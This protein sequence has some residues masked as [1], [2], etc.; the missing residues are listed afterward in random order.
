L[1]ASE[2]RQRS[3]LATIQPEPPPPCSRVACPAVPAELPLT[4]MAFA[5]RVAPGVIVVAVAVPA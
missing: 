1:N 4:E 3:A 2:R 5:V